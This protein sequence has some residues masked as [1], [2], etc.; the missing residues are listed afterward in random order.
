MQ[1]NECNHNMNT[2][3]NFEYFKSK[4]K[5]VF[6]SSGMWSAQSQNSAHR[7]MLENFN[8][9]NTVYWQ[10]GAQTNFPVCKWFERQNQTSDFTAKLYKHAI[11]IV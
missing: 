2:E 10:L 4:A 6:N 3:H 1:Q 7:E 8:H 5:T 11:K 9:T